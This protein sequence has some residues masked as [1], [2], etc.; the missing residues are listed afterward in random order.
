M[1]CYMKQ[2]MMKLNIFVLSVCIVV[3]YTVDILLHKR[4]N[5]EISSC[6]VSMHISFY[7]VGIATIKY[8]QYRKQYILM[9]QLLISTF[10]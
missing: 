2:S 10:I 8:P 5:D 7:I 3:F 9:I 4:V 6:I 1:L